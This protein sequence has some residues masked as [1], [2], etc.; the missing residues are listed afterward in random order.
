MFF[1]YLFHSEK[2]RHVMEEKK[3]LGETL[4]EAGHDTWR[5]LKEIVSDRNGLLFTITWF[6]ASDAASSGQ[7][8][9]ALMLQGAANV[10][11]S[12]TDYIILAAYQLS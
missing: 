4:K 6:L 12:E 11:S 10:S 7:T 8:F 3:Q 2:H 9:L 5:T 1:P